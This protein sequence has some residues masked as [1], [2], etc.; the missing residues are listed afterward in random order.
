MAAVTPF[1]FPLNLVCHKVGPA[2]AAGN[3]VLIKPASVTPLSALALTE[4]LLAVRFTRSR[5]SPV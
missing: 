1:N 2:I 4:L 5:R 3:A